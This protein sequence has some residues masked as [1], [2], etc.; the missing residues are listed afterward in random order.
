MVDGKPDAV[1]LAAHAIS[2]GTALSHRRTWSPNLV[3]Y[4]HPTV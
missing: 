4:E 2:V 3:Q 1:L